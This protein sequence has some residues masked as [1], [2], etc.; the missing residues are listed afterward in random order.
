MSPSYALKAADI[1]LRDIMNIS[2][3]FGGKIMVLGG[4]F[5]RVLPVVRFAN[6]SQL[7]AASLKSSELWHYFKTIRLSKNMRT[8]L[9]EE[10]F[11]EWLIKLGNG[12]LPAS[13]N[14]EIDLPTGCISDGNL[15]G[16]IFGKHISLED[17]P[18]LCDRMIL[19]PK[20]EHSLIVNEQVLQRL[21]GIEKV[22]SSVDDIEC[23]DGED[24]CNYPTEFL[25]SLTPSGL[26]PHK[27]NLKPGAIVMLRRN[28]D[29]NRRLC[30]G[31]R[32]IVR[33]LHN[34]TVDCEVATGS[35]KGNRTLIPRTSLILSVT[36]LPFKLITQAPVP[37]SP[38]ICYGY[39]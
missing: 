10:E 21:P 4:D 37:N 30:N 19:C 22:Y 16:E 26:P 3:P 9:S 1:L 27:P 6:R 33:R 20:N 23:D 18:N 13:E 5:R 25:N 38:V 11:S 12:E 31:T 15:V 35:N 39:Q 32:L 24:I 7:V 17:I 2:V 8:G 28:L 34:H 29:V 14:D 36:F